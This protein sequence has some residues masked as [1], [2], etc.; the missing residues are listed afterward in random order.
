MKSFLRNATI[1]LVSLSLVVVLTYSALSAAALSPEPLA[2]LSR[3]WSPTSTCLPEEPPHSV[4]PVERSWSK[5]VR[6]VLV[7]I[8][9]MEEKLEVYSAELDAI[10]AEERDADMARTLG[11]DENSPARSLETLMGRF[12]EMVDTFEGMNDGTRAE[13]SYLDPAGQVEALATVASKEKELNAYFDGLADRRRA[14]VE[15]QEAR[16][17]AAFEICTAIRL[18]A[19]SGA[20]AS[21]RIWEALA[22]E[23]GAKAK[24][25]EIAAG[26]RAFLEAAKALDAAPPACPPVLEKAG[27]E[28]QDPKPLEEN[29]D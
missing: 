13:L 23:A 20:A 16:E 2:G 27:P 24:V 4:Q 26:A 10:E 25:A 3:E 7:K 1:G 14:F 12:K 21:V 5:A 18:G 29:I 19:R 11:L 6:A 17:M 15:A 9:A 28:K 8:V 22:R